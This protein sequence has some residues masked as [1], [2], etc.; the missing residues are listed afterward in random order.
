[1]KI[2]AL[3]SAVLLYGLADCQLLGKEKCTWG[4]SY[5]C[6]HIK[7][8]KECG[9]MDHCASTVW[10]NQKIT[11]K[12][13][14]S[15]TFC[16]LMVNNVRHLKKYSSRKTQPYNLVA[17]TCTVLP[18]SLRRTCKDLV[19]NNLE[20]VMH[21]IST[22]LEA[23]SV[24]AVMELCEK[25]DDVVERPVFVDASMKTPANDDC[26]DCKAFFGD[27]QKKLSDNQTIAQ[28]ENMVDSLV[29]AQ[30]GPFEDLCKKMVH[31][32]V[33]I[34]TKYLHDQFDPDTMCHMINF[35]QQTAGWVDA[36]QPPVWLVNA[37]KDFHTVKYNSVDCQLCQTAVTDL[38]KMI[39]E[40]TVQDTLKNFVENNICSLLGSFQAK[41][42]EAVETY[43]AVAFDILANEL[44]PKTVCSAI[45]FCNSTKHQSKLHR[46]SLGSSLT[47]VNAIP[48]VVQ[49]VQKK[50]S[51]PECALCEFVLK[52][53]D[54]MIGSNRSE[55]AVEAALDQ[56]C[57]I[58]PQTISQECKDFIATYGRAI[59]QL[60]VQEL[61]PK[62]ICTIL[63]LCS[64]SSIHV[65]PVK[66]N[67]AVCDICSDVMGYFL[68]YLK[69]NATI[70][71]VKKLLEDLCNRLPGA[72][73]QECD[74]FVDQYIQLV[75]DL[76]TEEY[77]AK[78]ICQAI[79]LCPQKRNNSTLYFKRLRGGPH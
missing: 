34:V 36:S 31:H 53:I 12:D 37:I 76:I 68:K 54:E 17:K 61:D 48:R 64:M 44:D 72:I 75:M 50:V 21:L 70:E 30:L 24:C 77:S 43:A 3:L 46:V 32:Y 52:E 15:C 25:F 13:S 57:D 33:M 8:A 62:K 58:L 66:S 38:R 5:W 7:H 28:L 56:V 79:S 39:R 16:E 55:A 6:S 35:C 71:E 27:V 49:P 60:L 19:K 1:M 65:G 63:G 9:A 18:D 41:C 73:S 26:S 51:G 14:P 42:K 78:Q 59:I 74:S 10:K 69:Q 29:C 20:E 45:G 47:H 67:D 40:K 4:P 22:D 2:L 11:I 23:K